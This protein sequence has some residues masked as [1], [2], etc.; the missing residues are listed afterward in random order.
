MTSPVCGGSL[1]MMPAAGSRPVN[2]SQNDR[3]VVTPSPRSEGHSTTAGSVFSAGGAGP[4]PRLAW[5]STSTADTATASRSNAPR[6]VAPSHP[7]TLAPL[8]PISVPD[9]RQ[10]FGHRRHRRRHLALVLDELEKFHAGPRIVAKGPEHRARYR[11]RVL[12]L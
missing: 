8:R 2:T 1:M 7:R 3:L 9:A 5:A 4:R 6:T 10:A 11:E 12:L